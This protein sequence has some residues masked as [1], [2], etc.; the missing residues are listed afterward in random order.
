MSD[1]DANL[2]AGIAEL[3]SL[4][5]VSQDA[6][7]ILQAGVGQTYKTYSGTCVRYF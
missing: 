3:E 5:Q 4:F 6:Q 7:Q 2:A 1:S